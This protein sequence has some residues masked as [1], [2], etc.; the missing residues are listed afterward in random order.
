M[1]KFYS[2]MEAIAYR[3]NCPF[4]TKGL[5]VNDRDLVSSSYHQNYATGEAYP[6]YTFYIGKSTDD[7]MCLNPFTEE[8]E[9]RYSNKF[10]M[11]G[12]KNIGVYNGQTFAP[13]NYDGLFYHALTLN[14][15][16]CCRYHFTLQI[17]AD[18]GNRR[19]I[20]T[21]LNSETIS[22]EEGGIVHEVRNVYSTDKTEYACFP[23][24]GSSK[25]SSIPLIPLNIAD[26]KETISRIR[27]LLIFS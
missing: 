22:V 18:L 7:V 16:S 12:M 10:D 27:K 14:C 19:L 8:L 20:G 6:I 5:V 24:D 21:Y 3:A 1:I 17:H 26:P 4:C 9:I 25:R 2:F 11:Y 15:N 13:P 23:K